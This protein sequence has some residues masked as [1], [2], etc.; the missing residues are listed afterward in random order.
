MDVP[1]ASTWVR[2]Q[3]RSYWACRSGTIRGAAHGLAPEFLVEALG[4]VCCGKKGKQ[5]AYPNGAKSNDLSYY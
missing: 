2:D 5:V 1:D 4:L 3:L